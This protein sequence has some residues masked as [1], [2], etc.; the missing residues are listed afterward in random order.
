L[1]QEEDI[2]E[3]EDDLGL[4]DDEL[5][6]PA[7]KQDSK[8]K[9]SSSPSKQLLRQITRQTTKRELDVSPSKRHDRIKSGILKSKQSTNSYL[10][11][12]G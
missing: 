9:P 10:K 11:R 6:S 12:L 3:E 5:P 7:K 2:K 4:E 1:N 8:S